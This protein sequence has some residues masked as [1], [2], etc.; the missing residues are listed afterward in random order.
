LKKTFLAL[1]F[2]VLLLSQIPE[3]FALIYEDLTSYTEGGTEADQISQTSTRNTFTEIEYQD[4]AY[5]Y[6]SYGAQYFRSTETVLVNIDINMTD[7]YLVSFGGTITPFHCLVLANSTGDIADLNSDTFI[8]IHARF[9]ASAVQD[10]YVMG[11]RERTGG[12]TYLDDSEIF[13]WNIG[14]YC[15]F[16]WTG[17]ELA[18]NI[19]GSAENRSNT[20]G[21]L[22]SLS[23]ELHD[24]FSF[25]YMYCFCSYDLPYSGSWVSGWTE[26]Y[27]IGAEDFTAPEFTY[28]GFNSTLNG[29]H[30]RFI[31]NMTDNHALDF[32]VFGWNNSGSWVNTT[33][34]LPETTAN[35]TQLIFQLNATDGVIV[36]YQL[37]LND[38]TNN[39]GSMILQFF[40]TN[41]EPTYELPPEA[42]IG[43][44]IC[45][46]MI[47]GFVA[48]WIYYMSK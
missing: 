40:E 10:E 12:S 23:L 11:L 24:S 32:L 45:A 33:Y 16:N 14:Y 48:F 25:E 31:I 36:E 27:L 44:L 29:S 3:G 22:A 9:Y 42:F 28:L 37:W 15:L 43:F 6:K 5:C 46:P 13:E 4:E 20:E 47:L 2:L 7:R 41:T 30:S 19:Y 21:A 1:V 38:T 26:N 39:W 18:L 17:T 8:G 34:S 35:Q